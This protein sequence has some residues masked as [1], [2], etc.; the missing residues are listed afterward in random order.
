MI[1]PVSQPDKKQSHYNSFWNY[2]QQLCASI[3]EI[4]EMNDLYSE[5]LA[6]IIMAEDLGLY[7]VCD[8]REVLK[9]D[10][11]TYLPKG[12]LWIQAP[13]YSNHNKDFMAKAI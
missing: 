3:S 4:K 9:V 8:A 11:I 10:G 2:K 1:K 12:N 5:I 13:Y 6:K 7:V